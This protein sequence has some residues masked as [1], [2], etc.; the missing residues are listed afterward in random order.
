[1]T[2][3]WVTFRSCIACL[4]ESNEIK[5]QRITIYNHLVIG[6]AIFSTYQKCRKQRRR[7]KK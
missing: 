6:I 3:R 2:S 4:G 1:M 5:L 7:Y